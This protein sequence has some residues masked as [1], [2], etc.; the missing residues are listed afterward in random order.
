MGMS[1]R[2]I[3]YRSG[4]DPEFQKH[5]EIFDMC[6]GHSEIPSGVSRIRFINSY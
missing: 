6:I 1:T 2:I 4:D 5:K 3:G